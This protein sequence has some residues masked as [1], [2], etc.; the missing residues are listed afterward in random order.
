[1][2]MLLLARNAEDR[3]TEPNTL[4]AHWSGFSESVDHISVEAELHKRL[5]QIR[6]EHMRWAYECGMMTMEGEK[7]TFAQKLE[8]GATPSMW[9]TSLIYERHPRLSP[10]L[11][12]V[13]KLRCLEMLL[14]ERRIASLELRGGDRILK[15]TL[16][17]L[18]ETMGIGF[19]ARGTGKIKSD[20]NLTKRIYECFPAPIRAVV[21]YIHWLMTVRSLMPVPDAKK[22]RGRS[23]TDALIVSYFPNIDLKAA[24]GGRYIS[25]YW[26]ALHTLLNKEAARE[27]PRGPHF[28]HWLFIRFPAPELNLRQCLKLCSKFADNGKDGASFNYLEEFLTIPD[29]GKSL[30]RWLKVSATS[31]VLERK[32]AA[33]CHFTGSKLDFWPYF[34]EQWAESM[35]G[36]RCLERCLQNTAFRNYFKI[37]GQRRWVLFPLENC[38]WER[39]LTEAARIEAYNT[40]VYGAQ[41][42][43]IRPAD[44]RYFDDPGTF[45][46]KEC[47][48][49]QPDIFGAN[50]Q[51]AQKQWMENGMPHERLKLLEALRYQYLIQQGQPVEKADS[52]LPPAPGEPLEL[53]GQRLLVLTSFFAEETEAHLSLLRQALEAGALAKWRVIIKPHPYLPV[54]EWRDKLPS[55]L[56]AKVEIIGTPLSLAL[57]EGGLVWTSN[58]TTAALEAAL[59]GLPLMVMLPKNDFDL[60]PIQNIPGLFRTGTLADVKKGLAGQ[61]IPVLPENYLD[62]QPGLEQWRLL[63]GFP[64]ETAE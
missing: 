8:C 19:T 53:P 59:K 24:A 38:P 47:A 17:K 49:F 63:L 44:F 39:M 20:K 30:W 41:H 46:T 35:R 48:L 37:S 54:E 36:W 42:S 32:F 26:E 28:V 11:F 51:S 27:D 56:S 14:L 61:P 31:F 21:R 7:R 4:I 29:L 13:Y 64:H 43:I 57:S 60:C 3:D 22:I 58:S 6:A 52:I 12:P 5:L 15:K 1:M 2:R 50:G 23:R 25:R 16:A 33:N 55:S 62:L 18:C 40:P 9:W 45:S 10:N 34:R